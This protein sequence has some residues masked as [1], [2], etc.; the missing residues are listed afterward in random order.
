MGVFAQPQS[1]LDWALACHSAMLGLD[2][3]R[4]LLA[5][6]LCEEVYVV[7]PT[8]K[9]GYE[10]TPAAIN[11]RPNSSGGGVVPSPFA[12]VNR[13]QPPQAG[14]GPSGSAARQVQDAAAPGPS[15]P[16]AGFG[17]KGRSVPAGVAKRMLV[18]RGLR[19]KA[20]CHCGVT[21]AFINP[22]IGRMEYM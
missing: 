4:E 21:E 19:L 3:P 8:G 9:R 22:A 10:E 18:H 17:Q 11:T 13:G 2:W 12:L 16:T 7:A 5:H 1:C 14:P 20:G 15:Y 6:Q